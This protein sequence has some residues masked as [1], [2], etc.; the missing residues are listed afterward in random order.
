MLVGTC[1]SPSICLDYFSPLRASCD[2]I[3]EFYSPEIPD[4]QI[5]SCMGSINSSVIV[6]LLR[7]SIA[8]VIY[9]LGLQSEAS[10][11]FSCSCMHICIY[12]AEGFS[13][14]FSLVSIPQLYCLWNLCR[15]CQARPLCGESRVLLCEPLGLPRECILYVCKVFQ[16]T[17]PHMYVFGMH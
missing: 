2:S 5:N 9:G 3:T 8:G 7:M 1:P 14:F 16:L 15:V 11:I 10:A 17:M 4:Q 6:N 13:L 12:G